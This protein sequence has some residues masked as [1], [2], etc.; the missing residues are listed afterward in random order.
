VTQ[1][2]TSV[3]N[4]V[5]DVQTTTNTTGVRQLSRQYVTANDLE[6][7]P[8]EWTTGGRPV[9]RRLPSVSPTYQIDFEADGQIGYVFI[10]WGEGIFGPTTA[11]VVATETKTGIFVWG[12]NIIWDKGR[13]PLVPTLVD[14]AVLDVPPGRY[15][16]GYELF[17]ND[18]LF[19]AVYTV[20]DAA[21]T[22]EELTVTS[23]TDTVVG[24]RYPVVNAF[25]NNST[26]FWKNND[27]F[28]PV[29]SQPTAAYFS[30]SSVL[31]SAYSSVTVRCPDNTVV[32][33]T[34]TFSYVLNSVVTEVSTVS[35]S[36]DDIG[37]YYTFEV[38]LPSFQTGWRVDFSD[39]SVSI[40]SITVTGQITQ[41]RRPSG[42]TPKAALSLYPSLSAPAESV[43]CSLAYVEVGKLYEVKEIDDVRDIVHRNFEPVADWLTVGWDEEFTSLH[44]T[45]KNFAS[46]WMAP[47]TALKGE[48]LDLEIDGV[49]LSN[50]VILGE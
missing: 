26:R 28:F 13:T 3:N 49:I 19:E 21:L 29:Y 38:V 48:Y 11:E 5:I 41:M 6:N 36:S 25:L 45:I 34:A 27:S 35:V 39:L 1:L 32:T 22:G 20:E 33:G 30:W 47:P 40:Q 18:D 24:W 23:S 10:P 17:Y 2:L 50:S 16:C 43:F 4:G 12:G 7:R 44:D 37:Q 46:T 14:F 8:T 42:P 15:L 9:Y 31:G